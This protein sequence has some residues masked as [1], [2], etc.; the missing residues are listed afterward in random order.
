MSEIARG[1]GHLIRLFMKKKV[2]SISKILILVAIIS[3]LFSSCVSQKKIKYLQQKS[4]SDTNSYFEEK[5]TG[6]YKIQPKDNMYIRIM[7]LDEKTNALFNSISPMMSQG[8]TGNQD[9]GLYL[10]S[11][12]VSDEGYIEF[13]ILGKVFVK[14]LTVDQ[15][16][17]LLQQLVNEYIKEA[18]VVV[19]MVNFTITILGEASSPGL[20][21]V[22]Q[23]KINIFEAIAMAG[24]LRDFANRNDVILVRQI[25]E[26]SKIHH[27]DLT[28]QKLLSSD[29]YY[30]APNDILYI[31]PLRVKQYGFATFPY[32]LVFSS[33]SMIL[34]LL[35][36]FQV[37]KP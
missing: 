15:T 11:Y 34:T 35:V 22:Y 37:Y 16:K 21:S 3:Y 5:K 30:L 28:D 36:F 10:T 6:E 31:S 4:T 19:K 32:A 20:I 17:N 2:I 12:T 26:G 8:G 18:V 7:S 9:A 33:I 25:K 1:K 14:E 29:L 27:I 23:N 13:P 24:D